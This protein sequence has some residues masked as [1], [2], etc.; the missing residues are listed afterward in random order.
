MEK[1]IIYKIYNNLFDSKNE[2]GIEDIKIFCNWEGHWVVTYKNNG[3][4]Y[5]ISNE[6]I[7]V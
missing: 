1:E 7:T 6:F 5:L 4:K 3:E 2:L